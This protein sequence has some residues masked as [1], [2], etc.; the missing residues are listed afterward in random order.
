MMNSFI[1]I[2]IFIH[3]TKSICINRIRNS[4]ILSFSLH[5]PDRKF[6]H[7]VQAVA[8]RN[9]YARALDFA[10]THGVVTAYGSYLELCQDPKI[11]IVYIGTINSTHYENARIALNHNK[12]VLV[13][14]PIALKVEEINNLF[15]LAK[16]KNLFL[17]EGMW[18][19]CIPLFHKIGEIINDNVLGA[20]ISVCS[21]FPSSSYYRVERVNTKDLGG[22]GL[23]DIG[24]YPLRKELFYFSL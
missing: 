18:S 14:K 23:Y 9:N 22:G 2:K 11:D 19:R 8:T 1:Q 15:D 6:S 20:V 4:Y 13:E 16:S 12:H 21:T 5:S 3:V 10:K 17:M 7:V 24:C